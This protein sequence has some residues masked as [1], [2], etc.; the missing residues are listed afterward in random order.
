MSC[1][2]Q[3]AET[4]ALPLSSP[5]FQTRRPLLFFPPVA[6]P[7]IRFVCLALGVQDWDA[8]GVTYEAMKSMEPA[9]RGGLSSRAVV[10][11]TGPAFL[12]Q[13]ALELDARLV[14][15]YKY[16]ARYADEQ[17]SG[18]ATHEQSPFG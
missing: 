3:E 17:A 2:P 8:K 5:A 15:L 11:E 14:P 9:L 13:D 1:L 6:V 12:V 16:M 10:G 4:F 18:G 7:S